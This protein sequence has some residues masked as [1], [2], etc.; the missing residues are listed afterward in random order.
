[1]ADL[2]ASFLLRKS[3]GSMVSARSRCS[4][5]HRTPLVGERL[6]ELDSG[7]V[8]C[9]LCLAG[10]P[11]EDRR[12]VHVERMHATERQLATAPRPY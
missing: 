11:E 2:F 3:V 10:M 1:M 12:V 7:R 8:I 5:C 6:N 9:E 4:G